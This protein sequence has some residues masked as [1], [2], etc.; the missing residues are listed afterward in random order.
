MWAASAVPKCKDL[1]KKVFEIIRCLSARMVGSS[2]LIVK[3]LDI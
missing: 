2:V 1:C 3:Q